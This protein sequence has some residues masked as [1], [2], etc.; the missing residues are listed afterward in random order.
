MPKFAAN[1]SMLF[2]EHDFLDRFQAAA[3]AGFTAVEFLFPYE[4][5]P[6][7]IAARLTAADLQL[8]LHN[9]PPGNWEAGERGI[10]IL[11]DR[12]AEF[13]SGVDWAVAYATELGC[14]Q[15]NCLA[16]LAP[17]GV[18]PALLRET[19]IDN[20]KYAAARLEKAGLRL[21]VEAI[22]IR[23]MPGF[24]LHHSDQAI[25]VMDEVGADN[26]FL[27]YDIYHMQVMEGDIA[28]RLERL[29]PRI[30]H[31]Q[32]ADTPGRHEPGTGELNYPF[33]FGHLDRIGYDGFVSAEYRPAASTEAG[34]DWFAAA[35]VG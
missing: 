15:L 11:P 2:T 7:E 6:D 30:G 3:D 28:N 10:A 29:L 4:F 23:D 26:L 27:Q 18:D 31:I 16:G 32:I 5:Q 33:L 34:L 9:F 12:V 24:F 14:P 19:L 25:A 22:N 17:A 21:L 20:L 1:L 35:R 13:R 8:V